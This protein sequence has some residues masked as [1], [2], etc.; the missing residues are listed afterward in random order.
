MHAEGKAGSISHSQYT[1]HLGSHKKFTKTLDNLI[2][3]YGNL[4]K[5]LVFVS[6]G[7]TWIKNW[8]E[9]AFPKAICILDYYHACE[10]LHEFSSSIFTDKV[11][12]KIWTDKQKEWLLKGAVKTVISNIKR[13]GKNNEAANGLIN[14]YSKN[15]NRMKYQEYVKIGCGIIGSG[16]IESA[17]RTLVQ[18]RMK[19]SGQRWSWKGAQ[20]MLN[21]RVV[22]KNNDWNKI[23]ELSKATLKAVAS[24]RQFEMHPPKVTNLYRKKHQNLHI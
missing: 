18:K 9:D 20:H 6:D 4:G 8:I 23:I 13:V 3:K 22:R 15:K 24:M 2:D 10:H 17:H 12:E 14:Y 16:A 7:A 19:Q 1:A 21:L 5:R 11:K